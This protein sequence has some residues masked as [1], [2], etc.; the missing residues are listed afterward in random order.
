[1]STSGNSSPAKK[2]R[3]SLAAKVRRS[4][5]AFA[6]VLLVMV[7]G[8]LTYWSY[9][10]QQQAL[11]LSQQKTAERVS[12]SISS[13]LQASV[14]EMLL[15]EHI[16]NLA[17]LDP[18]GQQEAMEDLLSYRGDVFDELALLDGE[19]NEVVKVSE[20]R[21]YTPGDLVSQSHTPEF[22]A[23]MRGDSFIGPV[24]LSEYSL[25][26]T[27]VS[28]PVQDE[29]GRVRGALL[30]QVS[31]RQMWKVV[32]EVG[33]G[34]TGY[35][36]IVDQDGSLLA[37]KTL[38]TFFAHRGADL[39]SVPEVKAALTEEHEQTL[40]AHVDFT[41]E[42]VTS[43]HAP[44]TVE[45]IQWIAVVAVPVSEAYATIYNMLIALG[46]ILAAALVLSTVMG[47]LISR[48]ITRPLNLLEEGASVVGAGD[49]NHRIKIKTEDEIGALASS[50]NK[51]A[52]QVGNLLQ[53]LEERG[54]ELAARTREIEASQR[55]TFAASERTSPDELLRLVVN[56]MRDQFHLYHVQAYI[57]DEEEQAAVLRQSTG[58]AGRRLLQQKHHIPLDHPALVTKAISEGEPVVVNDTGADPNFMPNPLLPDTRSEL[59]VPLKTGDR[60]IGAL[61]AQ[62]RAAGRF[63]PNIVTLFQA[64][65]DQT[66]FLFENSDL[67]ENVTE[68]SRALT[69]F[70]DQ[71][72]T[73]ADI[74]RRLGSILDPE[75]LLQQVVELIRS[76]FGLY[77]AHI[78]VLEEG[79]NVEGK[80]KRELVVQAGSGEVGRVLRERG[81]SIP[82]DAEKSLVARAARAREPMLVADTTLD[83][84]FMPNP[85]LPQ[86]RSEM[87]V[88]LLAGDEVLGVLDVQD[89]QP[90]RFAQAE[91][92]TFATL[93]GQISTALQTAS[94]FA[95]VQA[96]FRVSQALAGAQTEEEVMASMMT[97]A[98]L[99]PQAQVVLA[100][101]D[102]E[103]ED[104]TPVAQRVS[105]FESGVAPVEIGTRFPTSRFKLI[106][107][108]SP[109]E[110]LVV[111]NISTDE[112]V[113][114]ATRQ[115]LTGLEVVST[116]II[117]ITA[118]DEQIGALQASS[119]KEGYFDERKL[120]LYQSI[121]EQGAIALRS[122]RL[123]DESQRTA[124]RLREL[125]I[126]KT[127]FMANMSH[128]LRTPLNSI[129]G[130]T[131]LMLMGVSEIDPDTLEDVQAIHENG[132]HLLHLINDILDMAKVETGS[133]VLNLEQVHIAPL[134]ND[135][136]AKAVKR[137]DGKPIEWA[138]EV[139]PDLPPIQ[140]DPLRIGQVLDNLV[141]NAEKFTE[142][143]NITLHA[144]AED[145][146]ACIE[147]RDTGIGIAESDMDKVFDRFQ[148][149]DSSSTRTA[150]GAGLGLA[151][152]RHLVELHGGTIEVQSQPGEGSTFTVRLP[153]QVDK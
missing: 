124:E 1:M 19:G 94:L 107:H 28:I 56:L 137:L 32:T 57:V 17:A 15:F 139:E 62:D 140:A 55:V 128:E 125:D 47:T 68:H 120:H 66:T 27:T 6:I 70:T 5:L 42:R 4:L 87:A 134:I 53:G 86:T 89:D 115:F 11:Y 31:V 52:E 104:S 26:M 65:A 106:D 88:P 112:R 138:V 40:S 79:H 98:S 97:A 3:G 51:M 93:A 91:R 111:S 149:V 72:R 80:V 34:E 152:A 33:L 101:Y 99:Y 108:L 136:S 129:I 100:L 117:N 130:Y 142:E 141:T 50:F 135:V 49:L 126:L 75:Q 81:H 153:V 148:Q 48:T 90:H 73:A 24:Y 58:F 103:S 147:I 13:Y 109:D 36:Y 16:Q 116:V 121:A 145:S 122:G 74:A 78:Y 84:D 96:R 39:S 41:G 133:L 114:P 61:D 54:D 131:E 44:I 64:M 43:A 132:Q 29:Y 127:E 9:Q 25:P 118:G 38:A 69:V 82:L 144:W 113:D 63:T 71:L 85:L 18:Q 92:D 12:Q 59:V 110:P 77:H 123:F 22:E 30:A 60:V 37:H 21:T 95:Q 76:R 146:W 2:R 143:G 35:T 119:T 46:L 102:Q 150:G 151:I 7:A 83:S 14:R 67:I 23:A 45:N 8:A 10:A 105:S 20:Y